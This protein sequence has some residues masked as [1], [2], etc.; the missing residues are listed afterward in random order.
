MPAKISTH[1]LQVDVSKPEQATP[2]TAADAEA[3]PTWRHEKAEPITDFAAWERELKKDGAWPLQ[4]K[5]ARCRDRAPT[6]VVKGA[7]PSGLAA[8]LELDKLGYNVV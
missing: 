6:A 2:G 7:G 8:A 1:A 5:G 3:P 4:L